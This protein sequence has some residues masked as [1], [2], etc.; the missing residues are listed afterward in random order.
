VGETRDGKR[1]WQA[2]EAAGF[3]GKVFAHGHRLKAR[4]M[5][6]SCG[7]RSG[8]A[9]EVQTHFPPKSRTICPCP[10]RVA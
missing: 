2:C 10:R 3:A 6:L 8:Q 1:G 4:G 7:C 9:P 5:V